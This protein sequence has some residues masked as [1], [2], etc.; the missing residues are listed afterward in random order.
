MAYLQQDPKLFSLSS[1]WNRPLRLFSSK[2]QAW[3]PISRFHPP[4][5]PFHPPHQRHL[6]PFSTNQRLPKFF[7]IAP[8]WFTVPRQPSAAVAASTATRAAAAAAASAKAT[9]TDQTFLKWRN[10]QQQQLGSRMVHI[11]CDPGQCLSNQYL[12]SPGSTSTSHPAIIDLCPLPFRP[13]RKT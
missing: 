8:S 4:H 13:W 2:P 10:Q 11:K 5:H 9:A 7:A 6:H 3:I 1:S 12:R